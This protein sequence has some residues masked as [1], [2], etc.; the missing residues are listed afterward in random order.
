MASTYPLIIYLML[1]NFLLHSVD[2]DVHKFVYYLSRSLCFLN[3]CSNWIFYCAS[4][5]LFRSRIRQL[6]RRFLYRIQLYHS[7]QSSVPLPPDYTNQF[8]NNFALNTS[9]NGQSRFTSVLKCANTFRKNT[10]KLNCQCSSDNNNNPSITNNVLFANLGCLKKQNT[11]QFA[12]KL[13]DVSTDCTKIEGIETFS[14]IRHN[15]LRMMMEI[16][17]ILEK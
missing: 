13:S 6:I 14:N 7:S 5:R 1:L 15:E 12:T 8:K 2:E 10:E 17:L 3:A 16:V 4:G 9:T 11:D